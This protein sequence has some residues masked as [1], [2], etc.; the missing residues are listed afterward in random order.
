VPDADLDACEDAHT[1]GTSSKSKVHGDRFDDT[2]VFALICRHGIPLC[3]MNITDAGEGQKYMLAGLEWL[4]EHLPARATVAGYYD[5]GCITDR[6]RQ[7]Y[8]VLP[9]DFSDRLVFVTSAMHS[10]AHQWTCQI[11]YSPR[12]KKGMGLTDGEGVER[13]WSAL[14]MLIPKLRA[15]SSL[16]ENQMRRWR[17]VLLNRQLQRLGKRMRHNLAKWIKKRRKTV[18]EKANKARVLL[19][20]TGHS[21]E[22]LTQQWQDQKNAELSPSSRLRKALEAVLQLQEQADGIEAAI[23]TA[24]ASFAGQHNS[25]Q[26]TTAANRCIRKL[27]ASQAELLSEAQSLYATLHIDQEFKEIRGMG[28]QFTAV[29]LQAHEAKRTCRMLLQRRFQEWNT[30][31]GAQGGKGMPVGTSIHT[32]TVAAMKKRT[33]TIQRALKVYNDLCERLRGLLPVGSTFPL[34]QPLSTELKHLKNNDALMQD[35]YISGN[36]GPAPAW[37]VDENVRKGIRAMLVIERCAE[38]EIRLDREARN[39]MR[40]YERESAAIDAA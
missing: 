4:S 24:E 20:K 23:A 12:M 19:A 26:A 25:R 1:A 11:V 30:L 31:D 27:K 7:L 9:G 15:V 40:W 36:E 21:H 18:V 34:P 10:Y 6:T 3:F 29:L 33:P 2:G 14:R 32:R 28:L 5:V 8:D 37:L 13:L 39:L 22:Y 35:V 38:E 16:M 17:L